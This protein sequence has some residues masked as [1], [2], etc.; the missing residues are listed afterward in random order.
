[1]E[2]VQGW[3]EGN[4]IEEIMYLLE[5]KGKAKSERFLTRLFMGVIHSDK[6]GLKRSATYVEAKIRYS[7]RKV[8]NVFGDEVF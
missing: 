2:V 3:K 8:D 6:T 1:M 5:R 7:C 4:T